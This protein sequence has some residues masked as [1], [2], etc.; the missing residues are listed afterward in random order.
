[1]ATT[2]DP[3]L[4]EARAEFVVDADFHLEPPNLEALLKYVDDDRIRE[5]M[6]ASS[7]PNTSLGI[8]PSP[9]IWH[10][11]YADAEGEWGLYSQGK[12]VDG[13]DVLTVME[14]MGVDM[15][16]LTPNLNPLAEAN[17]PRVKTAICS[18]YN[19][20]VLNE[21]TPVHEDIKMQ[22]LI[23]Q[24]DP[25]AMIEELDRIGDNPDVVG[26]YGWIV[27]GELLGKPKYDQVFEKLVELDLPWSLHGGGF[28][29]PH[30]LSGNS[31]RSWIEAIGINWPINAIKHVTN[32][33]VTG[34]F[35][36]Y[37][38]LN[39]LVQEGGLNWIPFLAYRLDEFYK[40]HPEDIKIIERMFDSGQQY[41]SRDP[42]E[43]LYENFYF[44]TQP[45]C[46]P[47]NAQHFKSMLEMCKAGQTFVFSSDWPHHTLDAPNWPFETS[48][49]DDHMRSQILHGN[50]TEV[51]RI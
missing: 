18:A 29:A 15:P 40:D 20:Y 7:P 27:P 19:D 46:P 50:A 47:P 34:V 4:D 17:Y 37:P 11:G 23:P 2:I 1:M 33:I 10:P 42:S 28:A 51:Y 45:I 8:P 38:D 25:D 30:T 43:Y 21:V 48:A 16:L 5:K 36:K 39:I 31:Q 49:V 35:E 22:A 9:S 6:E 26:A 24:W 44:A 13:D 3:I 41:L 12:A 32:M 14:D